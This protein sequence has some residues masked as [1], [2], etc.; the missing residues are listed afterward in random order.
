M[1][2]VFQPRSQNALNNEIIFTFRKRMVYL[3]SKLI[4]DSLQIF[5][6]YQHKTLIRKKELLTLS[7]PDFIQLNFI[8]AIVTQNLKLT[9]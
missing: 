4:F 3:K 1:N 8:E 2:F 5:I 9:F 7:L 6:S